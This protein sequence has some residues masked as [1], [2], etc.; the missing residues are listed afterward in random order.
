MRGVLIDIAGVL[1]ERQRAVAGAPEAFQRLRRAG[2]PLRLV[3]NTTSRSRRVLLQEL[4]AMGFAIEASELFAPAEA[5]VRY[6][7]RHGLSPHLLIAKALEED[8]ADCA[9]GGPPAVVVGDAGN[10]FTYQRLNA[11]FRLLYAG[12]PLLAL[13]NN[14]VFQD[15]NGK[16]SM[17]AGAFVQAL[18]FA[19]GARPVV[20]G[21]PS[22]DFFAAAAASMG[23]SLS[24]C[25]MIGDDAEVDV[26]GA[27]TAGAD[28]AFLVR[29]GK[30]QPGHETRFEPP[31]TAT[32]ADLAEAVAR[33]LR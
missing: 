11:A 31:P 1:L 22:P 25:V 19:S 33:I 26:A 28:A 15:S 13:A 8:F 3:T 32:V 12:A 14:R 30:Y 29:T 10:G 17:D 16:P 5:A 18:A 21:K 9:V 2:T 20:L 6:M 27:L 4:A 7:V 23:C 24:D